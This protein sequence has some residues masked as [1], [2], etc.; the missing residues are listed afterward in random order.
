MYLSHVHPNR[1]FKQLSVELHPAARDAYDWFESLPKLIHWPKIPSPLQKHIYLPSTLKG[2]LETRDKLIAK[3]KKITTNHF[4]IYSEIWLL[5][6]WELAEI[7]EGTVLV[8]PDKNI[9][10]KK[11]TIEQE[12]WL[13]VLKFLFFSVNPSQLGI[14]RDISN[15][16]MPENII[17]ALLGTTKLTDKHLMNW[18][19]CSRRTLINHRANRSSPEIPKE[20]NPIEFLSQSW[21]PTEE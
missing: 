13:S 10:L 5:R 12:A 21:E 19:G 8:Y 7:P 16:F 17:K 15:Q 4:Q 18:T 3:N 14:V 9:Q 2:V 20:I 1:K 6:Y 11:E